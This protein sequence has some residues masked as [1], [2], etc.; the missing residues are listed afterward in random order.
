MSV[1]GDRKGRPYA[2]GPKQDAQFFTLIVP[3]NRIFSL[4]FSAL[5]VGTL[6][7]LAACSPLASANPGPVQPTVT[8]NPA[9]QSQISPIPTPP[10]YRCGAWSSNNAP[11][12]GS[13]I[14]IYARLTK[15]VAGV[16]GATASAVVHFKDGDQPLDQQAT[17][18]TGGYV[19]FQLPLQ[20][21]QPKGVPATVDVTFSNFPGGP[22]VCTAFF[23][24]K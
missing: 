9:F 10:T 8:I 12:G 3:M 21:R 7:F 1:Q 4:I 11:G 18:D 15:D 24:P 23:T 6:L 20:G 14:T 5:F 2:S 19:S 17:S 13:T 22:L 16:S